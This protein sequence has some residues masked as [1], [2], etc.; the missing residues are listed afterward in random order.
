MELGGAAL[1]VVFF[2]PVLHPIIPPAIA[3]VVVKKL[4]R[5][6]LPVI[7]DSQGEIA[8]VNILAIAP[9]S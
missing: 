3:T 9:N 7:F 1:L 2:C 8:T 6:L 5:V 4:R